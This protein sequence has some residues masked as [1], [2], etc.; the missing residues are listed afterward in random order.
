[1]ENLRKLGD[2]K[3][4]RAPR[5][6]SSLACAALR[7]GNRPRRLWANEKDHP[8]FDPYPRA[9]R[10]TDRSRLAE[11]FAQL[12]L[13]PH[14]RPFAGGR[15]VLARSVDVEGEHGERGAKGAAFP[16]RASFGRPF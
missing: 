8:A 6:S 14:Q 9:L 13:R 1:M 10:A 16:A 12:V 15:Q 5:P 2:K 4:A 11:L 7:G 3:N